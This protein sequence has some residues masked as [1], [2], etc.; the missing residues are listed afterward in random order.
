M[1]RRSSTKSVPCKTAKKKRDRVVE[2]TTLLTFRLAD[3]DDADSRSMGPV[4]SEISSHTIHDLGN[5]IIDGPRT[6]RTRLSVH[7][8]GV[9]VSG[10]IVATAHEVVTVTVGLH[11]RKTHPLGSIS[12][13]L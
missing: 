3:T 12:G 10:R 11:T 6:V 9:D 8:Y 5:C 13:S 1:G 7:A 2:K 4:E